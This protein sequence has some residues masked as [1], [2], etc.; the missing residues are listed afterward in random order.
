MKKKDLEIRSS[1][2]DVLNKLPSIRTQAKCQ[3]ET[4]NKVEAQR[5]N[6]FDYDRWNKFDAGMI[7]ILSFH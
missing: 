3:E 5:I 2:D 7:I 1:T 4:S 6:S